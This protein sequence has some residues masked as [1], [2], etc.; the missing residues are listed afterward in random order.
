M[1]KQKN[2]ILAI[3]GVAGAGK[4]SIL[5][6]LKNYPDQ[7]VFSTSYSDR[8]ARPGE[9]S[10]DSYNLI[11]AEEFS[12]SIRC[13]EFL[14]WEA[15][16]SESRYGI[17]RRDFEDLLKSGKIVVMQ[18]DVK[19]M[20]KLKKSF[21]LVSI[22]LTPPSLEEAIRR[23]NAR[24]TDSP[25]SLKIRIDRYNLE[26][27]YKDK[28]DYVL[29][30]D[31]LVRAQNEL[32]EIIKKESQKRKK[33][34]NIFKYVFLPF[35]FLALAGSAYASQKVELNSIP[36]VKNF[37]PIKTTEIITTAQT[38]SVPTPISATAQPE[39]KKEDPPVIV[40]SPPREVKKAIE[41]EPPKTEVSKSEAIVEATKTNSDGSITTVVSTSGEAS[42]TDVDKVAASANVTINSISDIPFVDETGDHADLGQILKDY[43]NTALKWHGEINSL[44]SITLKDAGATGW[45]GQYLGSYTLASDGKDIVAESGVIILNSYYYKDSEI[46][47]DY[48]KLTFSHEYAHHYT[49]YHKWVDWDLPIATR[50]PDSYYSARSLSKTSTA[51]DY[52][53]GWQNCESEI[54]AEDY[55]YFYSGYGVNAMSGAYG[56]PNQSV[57]S[58]LDK[59]G[60]PELISTNSVNN[61]PILTITAPIAVTTISGTANFSADATDDGGIKKVSFYINGVLLVDDTAAPYFFRLNTLNYPNG[62]YTLKAIASDGL[63]VTEQSRTISIDNQ[64]NDTEKP[65]LT[66]L[67]PDSNPYTITM[68]K[69]TLH[70]QASDN[71]QVAKLELYYNDSLEGTWNTNDLSLKITLSSPGTYDLKFK[72]YDRAGNTTEKTLSVIRAA[73]NSK[74]ATSHTPAATEPLQTPP[75]ETP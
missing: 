61:P 31:D 7:F 18:I 39:I 15:T 68:S 28:Y 71:D 29:I 11:S 53:L 45:N 16:R 33:R 9:K 72:V 23:L 20:V 4:D 48:M 59:M 13:G 65:V 26:M 36:F 27:G 25:E 38:S 63:L 43:L 14:E 75:D 42:S 74:N 5:S 44:K 55:S 47:N 17:K 1:S 62:I 54:I 21:D 70:V 3:S 10:G 24:G 37:L 22:F 66:I 69:L 34:R 8:P 46:F 56:Y 51:V 52:S 57:S 60:S 30:N 19:G 35:L 6:C 73:D 2:F 50:L 40:A 58:W 41:K 32:L 12:E 67:S 49:L 64:T